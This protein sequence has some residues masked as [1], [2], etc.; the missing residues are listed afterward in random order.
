MNSAIPTNYLFPKYSQMGF[1]EADIL[2]AWKQS[3]GDE[4][5]LL[6]LLCNP[7][8]FFPFSL[9]RSFNLGQK[10]LQIHQFN[11][12]YAFFTKKSKHLLKSNPFAKLI[13]TNHNKTTNISKSPMIDLAGSFNPEQKQRQNGISVGLKNVGNSIF[14]SQYRVLIND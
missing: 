5:K 9:A 7:K 4:N 1:S 3:N 12:K 8:Y 14:I 2:R 10:N 13:P 6:D 11:I